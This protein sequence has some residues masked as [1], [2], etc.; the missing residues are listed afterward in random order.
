M[1]AKIKPAE[2]LLRL[3]HD[4][5][6]GIEDWARDEDGISDCVWDAY[7][8]AKDMLGEEIP[9]GMDGARPD[10]HDPCQK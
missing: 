10:D 4:L 2:A 3:I 7:L 5:V 6:R 9:I 1:M 8:T